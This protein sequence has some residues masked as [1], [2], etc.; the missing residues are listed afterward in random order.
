[1]DLLPIA[2]RAVEGT[3]LGM[4]QFAFRWCSSTRRSPTRAPASSPTPSR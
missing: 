3:G 2:G 4:A 1:M